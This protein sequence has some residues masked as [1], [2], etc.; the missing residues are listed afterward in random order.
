MFN[1]FQRQIHSKNLLT[2][3]FEKKIL[4]Y[5]LWSKSVHKLNS[6][7][8]SN[9][10]FF[11]KTQLL[12]NILRNISHIRFTTNLGLL[13]NTVQNLGSNCAKIWLRLHFIQIYPKKVRDNIWINSYGLAQKVATLQSKSF[14]ISDF[15]HNGLLSYFF[16]FIQKFI[17]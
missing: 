7:W 8:L 14:Q 3:T 13:K 15:Q 16:Y 11:E 6:N 2:S 12:I 5:S 17:S 4:M 9:H 1:K 10:I